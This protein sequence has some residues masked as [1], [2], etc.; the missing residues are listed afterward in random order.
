[1]ETPVSVSFTATRP[2]GARRDRAGGGTFVQVRRV[3]RDIELAVR[4][5]HFRLHVGEL[6]PLHLQGAELQAAI[7]IEPLERR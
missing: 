2:I 3:R 1:M 7:C 5:V 6:E 4:R